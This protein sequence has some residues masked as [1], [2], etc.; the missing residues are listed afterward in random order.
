MTRLALRIDEDDLELVSSS[1]KSDRT[2]SDLRI[3]LPLDLFP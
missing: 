1:C 3:E 2:I